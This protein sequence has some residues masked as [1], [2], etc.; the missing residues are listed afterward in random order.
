MTIQTINPSTESVLETYAVMTQSAIGHQIEMAQSRFQRWKAL[1]IETRV[2]L[3]HNL[4]K[5]LRSQAQDFA[6]LMAKEMGKPIAAGKAEIEKCALVCEYYAQHAKDYLLPDYVATEHDRSKV[7]YQPQG[8]IFA[9]MPWNFP[10]WQVFRF[11]APNLLAGNVGLLKHASISTG[12]GL[13]IK[14]AFL[15][16]GF[17]E[18]VFSTMIVTNEQTAHVIAHP[19]VR[20]VTFTGSDQTGRILAACA[21]THLKKFVAE[22]GGSDP[23]IVL[24]DAN[25]D[26][27]AE[28][29]VTSRLINNGQTCIAPKRI[30]VEAAVLD[31]L[32]DKIINLVQTYEYGDPMDINT[33]LGPMA[34]GD[35]RAQVHQ[36]VLESVAKGAVLRLG[37]YIPEGR[38]FFYPPT[39]L[40][41]VM[42][43]MPAF[44]DE[45]FGPVF[46]ITSAQNEAEAIKLANDNRYGL[47]ASIFTRDLERGEAIAT[48]E[49]QAGQVAVNAAVVSDPRLPF[50][51]IK[52]SGFGRE[53]GREGMREFMNT[54]AVVV[55]HSGYRFTLKKS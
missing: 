11:A 33:Q 31:S 40:T 30:I 51:G 9:V 25:L 42:P 8:I 54:K 19:L 35:L 20:G 14:K 23:C 18:H 46:A 7:S 16:A 32:T 43:G 22:L 2:E 38:G 49:L 37:G 24:A 29:V 39:V 52:H 36:Q 10:F 53:L 48:T 26:L 1:A 28:I 15:D 47:G 17:P 6:E 45:I 21:G 5:L 34:R 50:G 55:N 4:A 13:A 44:E 12:S 41:H 27:A 3:F